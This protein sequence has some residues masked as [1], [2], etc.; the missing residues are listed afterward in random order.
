MLM[1]KGEDFTKRY[2]DNRYAIYIPSLQSGYAQYATKQNKDVRDGDLP[3][4]FRVRDLDFLDPSNQL[5]SC[6]YTLYSSG[7]FDKAQ[8][9]NTDMI[10][11]RKRGQ[12][13]I[14]GDSGGFQLGTGVIKNRDEQLALNRLATHPAKLVAQW[15]DVGFRRRT[16]RWLEMY[17]DYAMTLDMVLW[18]SKEANKDSKSVLRNLSVDQ[19]IDLSVDNLKYFSDNRGRVSGGGTKFLNVL[20]DIGNGTGERWYQAVKDFEFEG[21]AYGGSTKL[22]HNLLRWCHRLMREKK[23]DKAEWFHLLQNSPPVFSV[24]YTAIQQ[25]LSKALGHEITISYDSS[26]PHQGSG[27]QRAM[28]KMPTFTNDL[29]TWRMGNERIEQNVQ[30]ARGDIQ[31]SLPSDSPLSAFFTLNDLNF[32]DGLYRDNTV[33]QFAEHL[34]TNHNIYIYHKAALDSC[35]LVF[36]K[37]NSNDQVPPE[38]D[39]FVAMMD[40]F[41]QK[42]D[43]ERMLADNAKLLAKLGRYQQTDDDQCLT[44][45]TADD[46]EI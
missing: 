20:Q 44:T 23:L 37:L 25:A 8:L 28:Y 32:H 30:L 9:R 11:D 39:D 13:V 45:F 19:L 24:V 10:R 4:G 7:Q 43:C 40:S 16:L 2:R 22:L 3:A 14:I 36:N 33:D 27:V 12:S 6:A 34:M 17:T 26:S 15:K 18:G 35:D 29:R 1:R 5:W 42:D 46:T 41:F 38:L 21:W 31:K